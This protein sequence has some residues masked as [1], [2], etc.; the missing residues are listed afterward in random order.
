M[1]NEDEVVQVLRQG[2]M[3]QLQVG[4]CMRAWMR[5]NRLCTQ[6]VEKLIE[7]ESVKHCG[8]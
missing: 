5:I 4:A 8:P 1:A 7:K 6:F 2:N 3:M